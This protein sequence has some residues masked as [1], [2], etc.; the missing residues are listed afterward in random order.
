LLQLL[1]LKLWLLHHSAPS[2]LLLVATAAVAT[3]KRY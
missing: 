3:G 1:L 2:L